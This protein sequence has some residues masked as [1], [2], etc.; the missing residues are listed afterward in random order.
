MFANSPA[1]NFFLFSILPEDNLPLANNT[2]SPFLSFVESQPNLN[3][4]L[5][6][7]MVMPSFY[8]FYNSTFGGSADSPAGS[9]IYSLSISL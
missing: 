5:S 7:I 4:T 3:T 6:Q 2:F 9:G 8:D 1:F